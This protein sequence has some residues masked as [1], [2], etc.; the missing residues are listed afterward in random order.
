MDWAGRWKERHLVSHDHDTLCTK[1]ISARRL[2]E[3]GNLEPG[4]S[5]VVLF[6]AGAILGRAL[7]EAFVGLRWEG[8]LFSRASTELESTNMSCDCGDRDCERI[9]I[10]ERIE[11]N[12]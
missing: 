3:L 7:C 8:R 11:G 6:I 2:Q 9:W 12:V 4:N 5:M 1:S 10:R